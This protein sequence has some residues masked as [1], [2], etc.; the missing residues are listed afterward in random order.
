MDKINIPAWNHF[1][2]LGYLHY[3]N[4]TAIKFVHK[5]QKLWL[6][7]LNPYLGFINHAVPLKVQSKDKEV[8]TI[9]ETREIGTQ[10]DPDRAM[11]LGQQIIDKMGYD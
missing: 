9:V 11:E 2:F 3:K 6:P 5:P 8:G 7:P 4:T 1:P 10:T